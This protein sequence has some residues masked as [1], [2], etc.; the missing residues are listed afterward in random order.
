MESIPVDPKETSIGTVGKLDKDPFIVKSPA[1]PSERLTSQ[2]ELIQQIMQVAKTGRDMGQ[3][4]KQLRERTRVA[5]GTFAERHRQRG[6]LLQKFRQ[7]LTLQREGLATTLN[8]IFDQIHQDPDQSAI[9]LFEIVANSSQSYNFDARQLNAVAEGLLEYEKKH[10][11]VEKAATEHPDPS[12]FFTA[13]FGFSPQGKVEVIKGPMTINFRCYDLEDYQAAYAG[14]REMVN[15][16]NKARSSSSVGFASPC[17]RIPGLSGTIIVENIAGN[18]ENWAKKKVRHEV[19]LQQPFYIETSNV[20]ESTI[21]L[22]SG[23]SRELTIYDLPLEASRPFEYFRRIQLSGDPAS[24]PAFNVVEVLASDNQGF[25]WYY[26]DYASYTSDV[27]QKNRLEYSLGTETI[28]LDQGTLVISSS[29]PDKARVVYKKE[30]LV[31]DPDLARPKPN[32]FI[33]KHEEQHQFNKLFTTYESRVVGR[34]ILY[35]ALAKQPTDKPPGES[36]TNIYNRV[37]LE[38]AKRLARNRRGDIIDRL[39]RDEIIASYRDGTS[40]AKILD[41][42][43]ETEEEAMIKSGGKEIALYDYAA[44]KAAEI[45]QLPKEVEEITHLYQKEIVQALA[46]D[47]LNVQLPITTQIELIVK[48]VFGPEYQQDLRHWASSIT[49]LENKGYSREEILALLYQY[50]AYRWSNLARQMPDK[51]LPSAS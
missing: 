45:K 17:S 9:E 42:L 7:D 23:E 31:Y 41:A 1:E 29:A 6:E 19:T 20:N 39:A 32:N 30:E 22:S 49:S 48:E 33:I 28:K 37:I 3:E 18:E 38:V 50:P 10:L 4:L 34:E 16:N 51:S 14:S 2:E 25:R 36:D 26:R 12:E 24:P 40:V 8:Q 11:A 44:Q 15:D 35:D 13:N 43:A 27:N 47:P 21:H 5:S 46:L